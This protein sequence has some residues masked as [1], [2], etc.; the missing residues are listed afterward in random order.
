VA[1][2][3]SLIL[4]FAHVNEQ[5]LVPKMGPFCCPEMVGGS[6]DGWVGMLAASGWLNLLD[7]VP[8]ID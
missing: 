1:E 8:V 5:L 4:L 6:D 3:L 7:T 2:S